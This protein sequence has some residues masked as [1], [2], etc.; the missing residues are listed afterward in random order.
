MHS[1]H[2]IID[3]L[4][5]ESLKKENINVETLSKE[6]NEIIQKTNELKNK[7]ENEINQINE[8]YQKTIDVM[9]KSFQEKHEKLLKE[10]NDLK[11]KLQNEVTKVKEQLE[12]FWSETNN[13]IKIS[14]KINLGIKNLEKEDKNIV[15]ILSYTS[16]INK[17]KKEMKN[18]FK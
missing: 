17:T 13:S 2:K 9:T 14:D 11:E 16:K 1:G 6:F 5:E 10:E 3:I 12:K 18:L 4:D 15:K 8:S 7:I